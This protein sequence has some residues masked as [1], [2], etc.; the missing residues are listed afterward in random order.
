MDIKPGGKQARMHD[1]WFMQ[2]GQQI[3]QEMCYPS[4]H[5]EYPNQPKGIKAVLTEHGV[6]G[7]SEQ[8]KESVKECQGS[9]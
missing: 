4:D 6:A 7:R 5:A 1:G 3:S 2:D 8:S 9:Q